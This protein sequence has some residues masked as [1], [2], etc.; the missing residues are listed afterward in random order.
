MD[1]IEVQSLER[2][3]EAL[4]RKEVEVED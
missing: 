2:N 3:W 4:D 1:E